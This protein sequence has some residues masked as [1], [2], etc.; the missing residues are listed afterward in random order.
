MIVSTIF[1]KADVAVFGLGRSGIASVKSLVE[2]GAR[3]FVWDDKE[4]NRATAK[5]EGAIGAPDL[6]DEDDTSADSNTGLTPAQA[7]ASK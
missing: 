2:G 3:V 6:S 1:A 7:L 5:S 4:E